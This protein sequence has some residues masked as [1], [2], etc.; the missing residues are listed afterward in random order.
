MSKKKRT[1]ARLAVDRMNRIRVFTYKQY[2][3]NWWRDYCG[4]A[5]SIFGR[6]N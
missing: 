2:K 3:F 5:F 4:R 6:V 1:H